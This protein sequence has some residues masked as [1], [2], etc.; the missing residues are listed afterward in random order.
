[1]EKDRRKSKLN[2]KVF[3]GKGGEK[4][5]NMDMFLFN[6]VLVIFGFGLIMCF[7]A[8][9]PEGQKLFND[10]YHFIRSQMIFGGIG[11]LGL[12][13][14]SHFNYHRYKKYLWIM[15]LVTIV[16]L[17]ATQF[18]PAINGS[19]RWIRFGPFTFQP[20]E[21]AKIT[22]IMWFAVHLSRQKWNYDRGIKAYFMSYLTDIILP[23]GIFLVIICA[24]LM[25]QPHFSCTLLILGTCSLMLF[26]SKSRLSH[27]LMTLAAGVPVL[28]VLALY[29]YRGD[30]MQ[31]FLDP[32]ASIQ[33]DG[34]Q[35]VQSYYALGS[36]GFFGLGLGQSRQK[37]SWLPEQYND[38]IYAVIGEELGFLGAVLVIVLFGLL[39]W[40]G[41]RI[42][43]YA[44][45]LLGK[46][47]A[48]G[49]TLLIALQV[50]IN[51]AVVTKVVPATG[52]PLPFFSYGG[53]A[54]M[55]TLIEMGILLNISR[56]I[57][58][59]EFKKPHTKM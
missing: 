54:I 44:P 25:L 41:L 19:Q 38:F 8:S 2:L 5:G 59:P 3:S 22:A 27:C 36:G 56:S 26:L 34:W 13:V 11:F 28:V 35:V 37:F 21:L 10:S 23:Y 43:K 15:V 52:M 17:I 4:Q 46:Y 29:G 12:L 14:A 39:I 33:G 53:T 30:R 24:L 50:T 55:F 48:L 40:R 1:M 51:L 31:S 18:F 42:V 6:L 58:M 45:D 47:I 57:D 7:S 20:S 16:L 32:F 49:I 9:A